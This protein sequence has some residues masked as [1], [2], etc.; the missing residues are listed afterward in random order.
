M[1]RWRATISRFRFAAVISHASGEAGTPC[2]GQV[3]SAAANA[4]ASASSEPA[5][6]RERETRKARSRPY[7]TRA[8]FSAA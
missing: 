4:S 7:E 3:V 8:A 1:V 6:S 2:K 5:T